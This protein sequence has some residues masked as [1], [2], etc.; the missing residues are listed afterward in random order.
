MNEQVCKTDVE[1]C[2]GVVG[3]DAG[4]FE[5]AIRVLYNSFVK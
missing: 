5:K 2:G 1:C 4:D 3:V